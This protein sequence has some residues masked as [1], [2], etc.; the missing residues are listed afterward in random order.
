MMPKVTV[1]MATF[2][3]EKYLREA[4]ESILSQTFKDFEFLIVYD[5]SSD[6]TLEI[7]Q[8][9]IDPRLRVI[10]NEER[11]GLIKSLNK[12]LELSTGEFIARMDSDDISYPERLETEVMLLNNCP[13]LYIVCSWIDVMDITRRVID[14]RADALTPEDI[15]YTLNFRN[16]IAN[17]TSMFRKSV[18]EAVGNYDETKV[19]EDYYFWYKA[20][21]KFMICKI[22]K[23]L[24]IWRTHETS[25][26][27]I[28]FDKQ[29]EAVYKIFRDNLTQLLGKDVEDKLT[30]LMWDNFCNTHYA[31]LND[32]SRHELL[33]I[34]NII[35]EL[36]AAIVDAAPTGLSKPS[37][38]D[39]GNE[40]Y[41]R[42]LTVAGRK[43]G[44]LKMLE[45]INKIDGNSPYKLAIIK[46][47]AG[48]FIRNK[49]KGENNY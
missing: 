20:S 10:V 4:V 29:K 13:W 39:L 31:D 7:L 24:Y 28:N 8:S 32:Y 40:K 12:G 25:F 46:K 15:Y 33:V 34:A 49:N 22:D 47:L 27:F 18:I 30:K 38:K 2:N 3:A 43:I 36:N 37:I 41:I 42:Y 1:L 45:L 9:Y 5:P 23:P 21:K 48:N 6:K 16:C 11:L 14:H 26:S 19:A 17:G 35:R 44:V